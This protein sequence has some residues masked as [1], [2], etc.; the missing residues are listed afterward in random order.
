[1]IVHIQELILGGYDTSANAI[2]ITLAL[3]AK[4]LDMQQ[5]LRDAIGD[6]DAINV[7]IKDLQNIQYLRNVV[8]EVFRIAPIAP[9]YIAHK[10]SDDFKIGGYTVPKD[11]IVYFL[12]QY[13]CHNAGWENVF[14]FDPDR[15]DNPVPNKVLPFGRGPRQCPGERIATSLVYRAVASYIQNF[16]WTETNEP[17][18]MELEFCSSHHLASKPK[19]CARD[20]LFEPKI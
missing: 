18:S 11:S 15:W 17:N 8:Q 5:K 16:E 19:F 7:P 6:I 2:Q 1:L 20:L 14:K 12:H 10:A 3:L 4:N 9:L 13:E